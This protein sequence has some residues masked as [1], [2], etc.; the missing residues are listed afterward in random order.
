MRFSDIVDAIGYSCIEQRD[1]ESTIN[2]LFG[3]AVRGWAVRGAGAHAWR[4]ALLE[5][6]E[7]TE[8]LKALNVLGARNSVEEFV[9]TRLERRGA[10]RQSSSP[11]RRL[12]AAP[13]G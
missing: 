10:S 7:A 4:R 9:H 5:G 8:E 12:P 6:L 11:P 13:S 1:V 2:H 3:M